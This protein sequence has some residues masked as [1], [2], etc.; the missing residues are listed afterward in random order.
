[1]TDLSLIEHE[2]KHVFYWS[3]PKPVS[4]DTSG[5]VAKTLLDSCLLNIVLDPVINNI[6]TSSYHI[7]MRVS[8][9]R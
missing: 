6:L 7:R 3:K 5:S 1:M 4:Y 2:R 9:R 8:A